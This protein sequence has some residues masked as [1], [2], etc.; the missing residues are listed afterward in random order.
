MKSMADDAKQTKFPFERDK[1]AAILFYWIMTP[2]VWFSVFLTFLSSYKAYPY[3]SSYLLLFCAAIQISGWMIGL[4]AAKKIKRRTTELL[5]KNKKIREIQER[6]IMSIADLVES[7]DSFTGM[8]VQRTARYVERICAKMVEMGAYPNELD[9]HAAAVM[10]KAAPLHDMGK[11]RIPETILEK[12]GKLNDEEFKI[13]KMHPL[14]GEKIIEKTFSGIEDEEFTQCA[15][16]MALT[17]HEKWDGTG[18]PLRLIGEDIPLCGRIMAAADVLDAL[19]TVRPYKRAFTIAETMNIFADSA[20]KQ[21]DPI[22]AEAVL[23]IEDE[24]TMIQLDTMND[25]TIK[26]AQKEDRGEPR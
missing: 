6:L 12:P 16:Q 17:H 8:H 19:L 11:I 18:Y 13:I 24:I 26:E 23:Q 7:K 9:E 21:F 14:W 5:D 2:I 20:G 4:I 22:V 3:P 10:A 25:Y 15:L 1:K